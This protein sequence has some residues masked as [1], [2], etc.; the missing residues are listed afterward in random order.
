[1]F[2]LVGRAGTR[3]DPRFA[4][5]LALYRER[6]FASAQTLFAQLDGDETAA[7]MATRCAA[8]A[9]SPPGEDW[10]GVYDQRSK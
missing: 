9:A 7:L 4:E 3:V 8:L 10:D 5:A 2:E 6:E 1:V